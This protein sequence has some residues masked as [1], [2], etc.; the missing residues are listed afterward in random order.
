MKIVTKLG[1]GVVAV[2]LVL[3]LSPAITHAQTPDGE[4]PA[5]EG[6]CDPL[7]GGTP[8][9]YGLCVAYCEAQ[10]VSD[11]NLGNPPSNKIL[12]VYNKRRNAG[13]PVMPCVQEPCPCWSEEDLQVALP[14][15]TV[16]TELTGD[17]EPTQNGVLIFGPAPSFANQVKAFILPTAPIQDACFFVVQQPGLPNTGVRRE[18]FITKEQGAIC[19]ASARQHAESLGVTCVI[20]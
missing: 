15:L 6:V 18:M 8:G 1:N 3:L 4:T 16:C 10:D 9:L 13:D 5:N 11:A 19:E 2:A 17:A 12:D 7:I 20:P 14:T